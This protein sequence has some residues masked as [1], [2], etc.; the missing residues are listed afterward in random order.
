[1]LSNGDL[2]KI[3]SLLD[4][5]LDKK[6]DE[7]LDTKLEENN[8]RFLKQI[9][10][11]IKFQISEFKREIYTDLRM[12]LGKVWEELRYLR[13]AIQSHVELHN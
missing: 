11:E 7:K 8:V 2:E 4:N 12:E 13:I 1:M 3:G 6:L 9:R 10:E 5:K